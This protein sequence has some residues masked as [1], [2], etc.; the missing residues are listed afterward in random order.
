M[1]LRREQLA[2]EPT[3]LYA[4]KAV[5][6]HARSAW[7]RARSGRRPDTAGVRILAYHRV[8]RERDELAVTPRRFREQM[9][10]LATA[11]YRVV[12][13]TEAV[14]AAPPADDRPTV[15]LTFDDGY[16]DV[17]D[18]GLPVLAELGFRATVFLPTGAI[19]GTHPFTWYERPPPLLDWSTIAELD[20]DS[21][22]DFGA[23][24]VTHANLL[25]LDDVAASREV[26]G[27][28]EILEGRLAH[29][30]TAFCYPAGLH[31]ARE[32][33]LVRA[34]GFEVAVGAEPGANGPGADRFALR[35]IGVGPRDRLLDFRA[36]LGGGHD[37][38]PPLRSLYRALRFGSPRP[39]SS[40][41]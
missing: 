4:A 6:T 5:Y 32:R 20:R 36:K 7:W 1:A 30:V 10:H 37:S 14:A 21:P 17:V 12:G 13:A 28:K 40:R 3:A 23:H 25:A 38:P 18:N 31:G 35:R 24:S 16:R 9:E 27:S 2:L 19:D 33:E 15:G 8:S 11:G 26:A 39:S 29:P 22:L 41:A 34:S